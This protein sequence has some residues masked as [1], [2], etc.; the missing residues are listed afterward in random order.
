MRSNK[1][2]KG[3]SLIE[4]MIALA[5][6][7]V[8]A[9]IAIPLYQGYLLEGYYGVM[10]TNMHDLRVLIEDYRLDNGD[11][12]TGGS[13]FTGLTQING[14]Y[15]WNPSGNI[16]GYNYTVAVQAGTV[17][18]DVWATHVS[19]T[20]VRCDDRISNCCEGSSGSPTSRCP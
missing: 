3:F 2:A 7:F 18:Y 11:Y 15:G 10:R 6:M 8:V 14:Q 9:G 13:Q 12:G 16:G 1:P 17:S 4:L 19:G 20:W 5:I